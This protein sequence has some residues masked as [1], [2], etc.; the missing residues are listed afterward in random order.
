MATKNAT[1]KVTKTVE[2]VENTSTVN[3]L[4]QEMTNAKNDMKR[5]GIYLNLD[6]EPKIVAVIAFAMRAA[7]MGT[8]DQGP[9]M[10]LDLKVVEMNEDDHPRIASIPR[11]SSIAFNSIAALIKEAGGVVR[12]DQ[13]GKD[14]IKPNLKDYQWIALAKPFAVTIETRESKGRFYAN[15]FTK[16]VTPV[17]VV[18]ENANLLD[19]IEAI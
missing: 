13:V 16:Y 9:T 7:T 5:F 15:K 11:F 12:A 8:G 1:K 18:D 19:A 14:G 6:A 4:D 17:Q 2:T 10:V 3:I